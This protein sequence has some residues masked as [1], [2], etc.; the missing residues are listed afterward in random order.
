MES[1]Q[2]VSPERERRIVR[3]IPYLLIVGL[4][5]VVAV[6]EPIISAIGA[7]V[8][9]LL[10][11]LHLYEER[12]ARRAWE[13]YVAGISMQVEETGQD[14]LTNMPIGILLYDEET[15]VTWFNDPMR[16]IFDD[17]A[18][19]QTL[20]ELDPLFI[21]MVATNEDQ[22]TLEIGDAV[23]RV[24]SNHENRTFYLFDMTEE[25]QVEQQLVDNQTVIGVIYLDNY[26]EMT[27]GIEDQLRSELNSR[28]TQLLN[29]WAAE[30]GTYI[31]RTA[32]DR[33]F[34]VTTEENL[35][36]L[37]RS[38][39]TILDTVREE[40][41]QR[42]V[43]L[44]L[45]IGIGCGSDPIPALGQ[46]AQS[47]LDLALGR[48][49]DQVVIKRDG[50]VRFYGGKT[51]PTE[52][53]TRVRARVIANSLRDLMQESSRVLIM[54]HKNPD[55]DALGSAIGILKLAEMNDKEAHIVLPPEEIGRGIRRMM[56]EIAEVPQLET[57]FVNAF[58]ADQLIDD[59]TLLVVV[60]THKPSLVVVP[61]LLDRFEHMVVIDHH[62]RG[63]DFIEDAVLVY[64]EP[65]ASSTSEL[66]TE[67]IEYQP[68]NQKLAMLE[69]TALLAGIIVDTKGFA[70]RT[71][72]RT[73]DAASYLRSQGADTV[74][75]QEFL[76]QDL[77]TYV[78]QSH[79]LER[80]EVYTEGMAIATAEPGVIHDQV[81]IA[82]A[83]DQLLSLRG[84]RAAFVIAELQD[85]RTAISAR[86][87]GDVNVQLIMET[88]GGGGHLTN[89]ATQMSESVVTVADALRK[90]IDQ[91][92]EDE[93]KG[94]ES[95]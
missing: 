58:Q 71:G 40:T 13:T 16:D 94:E 83:A 7:V 32:S 43:Q 27:Q 88:L 57:R 85:G 93:T 48:G 24:F 91:Y 69:A 26:D 55:M 30:H 52:K 33:Y 45:S 56:D 75:V 19:G 1:G 60:D 81:L 76:S 80:S 42:G 34:I 63:E 46:M 51:N 86:S 72:S 62:R 90:A 74:L 92:L 37:E 44:T 67:L 15:L 87:L 84:I 3:F 78:E 9:A 25:A 20:N 70:L 59:Q 31:K 50:K 73:F 54:G 41:S 77:E 47:S 36:I 79:I 12:R 2:Q 28:V 53:R 66:V 23:Y 39:F 61:A 22:A 35:R 11:G 4:L 38:K 89:A 5:L 18:M 95:E 29:H 65:Y 8:T 68:T 10:F 6:R 64:L 14:A 17:V 21:E 49:G 82:Q